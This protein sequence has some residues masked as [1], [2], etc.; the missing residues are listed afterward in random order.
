[1]VHCYRPH[2]HFRRCLPPFSSRRRKLRDAFGVHSCCY[3]APDQL[4]PLQCQ[5]HSR[6]CPSPNLNPSLNLTQSQ[7]EGPP[8]HSQGH[9]LLDLAFHMSRRGNV[10]FSV[11]LTECVNGM[12]RDDRRR[13]TVSV[14]IVCSYFFTNGNGPE[15]AKC[16]ILPFTEQFTVIITVVLSWDW[17][18]VN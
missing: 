5:N 7:A 18:R 8:L 13:P 4:R 14:T 6:M 12:W 1:M 15:N 2:R 11:Q 3:W 10:G 9:I 16:D 17:V